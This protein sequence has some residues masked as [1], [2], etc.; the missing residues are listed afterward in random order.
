MKFT[1]R[2]SLKLI[3][4]KALTFICMWVYKQKHTLITY[5]W[6][7]A[8]N[9]LSKI[10]ATQTKA[11]ENARQGKIINLRFITFWKIKKETNKIYI[12]EQ[13]LKY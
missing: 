2:I 12:K 10:A 7:Y 4:E 3:C 1:K 6:G 11:R 8:I 9:Y 5:S 13:N